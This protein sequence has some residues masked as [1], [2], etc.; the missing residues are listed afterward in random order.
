M[1]EKN[2]CEQR[3]CVV[4]E[5]LPVEKSA[6]PSPTPAHPPEGRASTL[7]TTIVTPQ[8]SGHLRKS[9]RAPGGA[10]GA[11]AVRQASPASIRQCPPRS[12]QD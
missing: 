3:D 7:P 11:A 2:P 4:H 6:A 12:R 10:V 1:R 9:S 5:A 8:T